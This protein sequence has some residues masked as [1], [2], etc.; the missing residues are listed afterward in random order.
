MSV[1]CPVLVQHELWPR[2]LM[3]LAVKSSPGQGFDPVWGFF[4]SPPDMKLPILVSDSLGD[5]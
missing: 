1:Q 2:G 4:F 5:S 3:V